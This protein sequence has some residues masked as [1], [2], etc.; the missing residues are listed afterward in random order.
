MKN[1]VLEHIGLELDGQEILKDVNL[2]LEEG[3]VYGLIGDNGAG[4]SMLLQVIAGNIRPTSGRILYEGREVGTEVN[5]G[6]II[7][8]LSET[9]EMLPGCNGFE[10]LVRWNEGREEVDEEEIRRTMFSVGLEPDCKIEGTRYSFGNKRRLSWAQILLENRDVVL[11]DDPTRSL[12][13]LGIWARRS[14]LTDMV[15]EGQMVMLTTYS[16]KE[17]VM[18]CDEAFEIKD[19]SVAE[20]PGYRKFSVNSVK[21]E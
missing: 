4:K 13:R 5:P 8:L 21:A 6:E 11:L 9:T 19:G 16:G 10:T 17:L 7:S 2:T 3:K 18:L 12:D 20:L 1:L 15:K 14:D